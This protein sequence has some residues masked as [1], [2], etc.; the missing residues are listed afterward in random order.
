MIVKMCLRDR[1][2]CFAD[3]VGLTLLAVLFLLTPLNCFLNICLPT[4]FAAVLKFFLPLTSS[5]ISGATNSKKLAPTSFAAETIFFC[6][7]EFQFSQY[8]VQLHRNPIHVVDQY[9]YRL[10][11][12]LVLKQPSCNVFWVR[13]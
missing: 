6:Q 13:N 11:S 12:L 10:E 2:I 8:L 3:F 4:L 1:L 5:A 7:I 9:L